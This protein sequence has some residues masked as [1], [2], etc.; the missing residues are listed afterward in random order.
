MVVETANSNFTLTNFNLIGQETDFLNG[1]EAASLTGGNGNNILD[2][3]AFTA[4]NVTLDGAGG[5]DSLVGTIN[6]D[7]LRGGGGTDT[8][9]GFGG[10]DTLDG[11]SGPLDRLTVNGDNNFTLINTSLVVSS[12]G[13]LVYTDAPEL[14]SRKPAS[15]AAWATTSWTLPALPVP[16]R[17]RA[18]N[19]MTCCSADRPKTA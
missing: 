4:G 10:N 7:S 12:S 1:I 5:N 15:P 9:R 17:S 14:V 8:L 16:S 11:G 6:G 19:G 2:A 18:G 3:S 13:S